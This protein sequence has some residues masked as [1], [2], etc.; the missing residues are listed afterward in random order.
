MK[1][2]HFLK[3]MIRYSGYF[4]AELILSY[5][6]ASAVVK[7]NTV[8]GSAVD[9]M[10]AGAKVQLGSFMG[11]LMILTL[12]GFAA[13]FFKS[14][15]ASQFSIKVQTAYKNLVARKLYRLEYRYFDENG[16]AAVI[17]KMNSDI[18]EADTLL[19]ENL[20]EICTNVVAAVTYA[21]YVG[22]LN[23]GLLF[24]MLLCYP[25][26]LYITN[27]VVKK[28]TSLKKVFRQKSDLITEIAQ[29]CISGILVLRAF[30]AEKYFQEK[31]NQAADDL[32][33]NEEKRTRISNTA[34]IIRKMLQWLPNIICAVYAYFL[35]VNGNLSVG[36]LMTFII[37]LGRFVE[38]FVGLPFIF[39][40]AREHIVCIRRVENILCEKDE[41]CGIEKE[42]TDFAEAIS[43]SNVCF[44]YTEGKQVLKDLSFSVPVGSSVAFAGDSGGG[45]STVFHILCGF[46]PVQ[47]GSY[48]LFGREFAEWDIEAAREK[49]AL[50][51]QNVFLFPTT[52][53]ENVRYGNLNAS[54][55]E[56]IKACRDARI[57]DFIMSL[58]EGYDTI[59]GERG[60]LLSGGERQRISIARAFLKNAPVLLLDEPTS[61]VDVET[62]EMIQK[63]IEKLSENRTCIT[64]AHR[65]S[66]IRNV[67]KI[68]VLKD[69][70]IAEAGSHEELMK[71]N[72]VYA[73]MYG[74]EETKA[75]DKEEDGKEAAE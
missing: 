51:S 27:V 45:K 38:A 29:D 15:A 12:A 26:I 39:V 33:D 24:L 64:I 50:V 56:V 34:L 17:N 22:R 9:T 48:R 49:L 57:H 72:G 32:V 63:A 61:A 37:I 54:K 21:V 11:Y 62:E 16:S 52:I 67:D 75:A 41:P 5:I 2:N 43:F 28:I 6:L 68:M 30:G 66:T 71:K 3:C 40:D 1:Q 65:L 14:A 31:L 35:V 53:Y 4:L 58:P 46:Y 55:E 23:T 25:V 10:L 74:K 69:G 7:G 13:A 18:A 44:R 59:V 73:G 20:P 19:N 47:S 60:I 42:G 36:G 70:N 8:I